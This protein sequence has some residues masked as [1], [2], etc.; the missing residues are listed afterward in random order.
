M[1]F[2]FVA[3]TLH[4]S[5]VAP[6]RIQL[7]PGPTHVKTGQTVR[8]PKCF[9]TG[10]PT[11]V[12]TW[13]IVKGVLPRNRVV[14]SKGSLSLIA[15]ENKDTGLYECT[16]KNRLGHESSVTYVVV[17]SPPTFVKKP[18][19]KVNKYIGDKLA[20]HCSASDQASIS[21]K[22]VG[23]GWE[24]ERMTDQNGT[25]TITSLKETDSG[26]YV[27]EAKLPL[28]KIDTATSLKVTGQQQMC[29]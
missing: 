17:W 16:A 5:I 18:P 24:R 8:L 4:F 9:A 25:L 21:W 10:F 29:H 20:L 14:S 19:G 15:A 22:R 1:R 2:Y 28:Y 6:P 26:S 12:V 23:G 3:K 11:P 13:R 7:D 27:C